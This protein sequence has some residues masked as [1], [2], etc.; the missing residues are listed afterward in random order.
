MWI[1]HW[2]WPYVSVFISDGVLRGLGG[3]DDVLGG[4]PQLVGM[5]GAVEVVAVMGVEDFLEEVEVVGVMG[6]VEVEEV[7]GVVVDG[8]ICC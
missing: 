3:L 2:W 1:S 7:V 4:M 8:A 6:V 5:V